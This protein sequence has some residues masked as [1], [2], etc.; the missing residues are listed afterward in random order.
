MGHGM[1]PSDARRVRVT[2]NQLKTEF[3]NKYC[4]DGTLKNSVDLVQPIPINKTKSVLIKSGMNWQFRL[5][6]LEDF[7][8]YILTISPD[9][10]TISYKDHTNIPNTILTK[11]FLEKYAFNTT[12]FITRIGTRWQIY[13]SQD[14]IDLLL[15]HCTI[16]ILE[17]GR[18]KF[19]FHCEET[20]YKGIMTIEYRPELHKKNWVFGAHGG[21]A[22]ELLRRLFEIHLMY[23]ELPI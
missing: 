22:G 8:K 5:G 7:E 13:Y 9:G 1:D 2:G 16:R 4:L 19:D 14:I 18:I 11:I 6:R 17:T 3:L 15:D 23:T 21:N 10:R 12:L 20:I